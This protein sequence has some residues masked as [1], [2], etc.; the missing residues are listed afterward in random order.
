MCPQIQ[1]IHMFKRVANTG[2]YT[3]LTVVMLLS[4]QYSEAQDFRPP[5]NQNFNKTNRY[6][7]GDL[8]SKIPNYNE[9]EQPQDTTERKRR[10]RKPLE[11]FYFNDSTRQQRIFSWGVSLNNNDIHLKQVDTLLPGFEIDYRFM[12]EDV[13]SAYLGNLGGAT[14]PLNYFR[15]PEPNNFSFVKAWDAYIMTPER[16]T[17]Y[18]AK[19][20]Y[21][22][23]SYEMSGQVLVEENAFNFILSQNISPSTSVGIEYNADATKG[24]Y[25]RQKAMSRYFT[26]NVAHTGKRYAIHGG[27]IYNH[28]EIDENGGIKDDKDIT[29][30]IYDVPRNIPINLTEASNL[31]RGHTFWLTQ[32]Y[33]I[34]LRRQRDEELT[35]QQIPTIYIGMSAEQTTFGRRYSGVKDTSFYK[36][37]YLDL[38]KSSD[39]VAQSRLDI[40]FFTQLQPYNRDGILGL[41]TAGIGNSFNTFITDTVPAQYNKAFG[42]GG[43]MGRNST[44]LYGAAQGAFKKYLRWG[45]SLEYY[46]LGYRSGDFSLKGDLSVSAYIKDRP[47][48]LDA[49]VDFS[50]REPDFWTQTYFSNHFAWANSFSKESTTTIKARFSIPSISMELGADYQIVQNKVYYDAASMPAQYGDPMSIMGIYL[51]KNFRA[52]GF[53]F[54]HRVLMQWSTQQEVVP[55]PAIS[56]F[57]SYFYEFDVVRKVLRMELGIDGRFNTEYYGFA[58]NPAIGQF[59][60]QREKT[61]GGYPYLDAFAA[62][63]WKRM[64]ILLKL[65]HF[66]ANLLGEQKYFT[67]LHQPMNRMM[68]KIGVSWSFYD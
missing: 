5:T 7:E 13:G 43:R 30:T 11:S 21:S 50:L 28:G 32:S 66:N 40:K 53:H 56:A 8:P 33:G 58:F 52:G 14:I 18:N 37:T 57:V 68:F 49:S 34:P 46:L 38:D 24:I 47:L 45:A 44:Y 48:T 17:F 41:V 54:N 39:S 23:L 1:E 6:G 60:N 22:R 42:Q 26:V 27:Y 36:T 67:V 35:I 64:R 9:R 4:A 12:R 31:Y 55:V 3:L 29:D 63:K 61:I 59:Y 51:Q 10:P 16:A 65:Q 20:P 2:L 62:A 19:I 25:A 15:R